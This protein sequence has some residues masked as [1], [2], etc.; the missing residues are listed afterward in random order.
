MPETAKGGRLERAVAALSIVLSLLLVAY[1]IRQNTRVATASA[2]QEVASLTFEYFLAAATDPEMAPLL[3]KVSEGAVHSDFTPSENA[4]VA[5]YF[6]AG[7]NITENRFRQGELGVIPSDSLFAA[8][9]G[10]LR[11]PY[12]RE[13]WP[14]IRDE[15]AP[16]FVEYMI[17]EYGLD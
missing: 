7:L 13:M 3:L 15:R 6:L 4:R 17:R 9:S 5:F 10:A 11:S 16:D 12:F 14:E 8:G 2:I 1:E